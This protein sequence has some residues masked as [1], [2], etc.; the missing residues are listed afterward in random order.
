[1]PPRSA[2]TERE[3][4]EMVVDNLERGNTELANRL[5]ALKV[6]PLHAMTALATHHMTLANDIAVMMGGTKYAIALMEARIEALKA[7][8]KAKK[9]TPDAT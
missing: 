8:A 4:I 3:I 9:D 6:D 2:L 7:K 1:V 5:R